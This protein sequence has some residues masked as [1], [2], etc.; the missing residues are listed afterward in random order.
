M[1]RGKARIKTHTTDLGK[2]GSKTRYTPAVITP[3]IPPTTGKKITDLLRLWA[4]IWPPLPGMGNLVR[5]PNAV[6][7]LFK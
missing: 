1:N 3:I 5:K 4:S 2:N 6:K 7:K